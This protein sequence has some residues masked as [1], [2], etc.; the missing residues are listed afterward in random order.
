MEEG[1]QRHERDKGMPENDLRTQLRK[2]QLPAGFQ[3]AFTLISDKL[4]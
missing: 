3:R 1:R 4:V 2:K